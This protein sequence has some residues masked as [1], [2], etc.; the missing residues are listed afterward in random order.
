VGGEA[1]N[2]INQ[3]PFDSL[4]ITSPAIETLRKGR[5]LIE[6]HG[7][8]RGH[9]QDHEGKLCTVGAVTRQGR[10]DH[11]WIDEALEYLARA[12]SADLEAIAAWN[13]APGRTQ[14]DVLAA[15]DKAIEL[16]I[17]DQLAKVE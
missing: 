1:R 5:V 16:A 14:A 17:A 10:I 4:P 6:T 12:I 7:L 9:F 3:M 13:D 11:L 8:A 2:E 15:F